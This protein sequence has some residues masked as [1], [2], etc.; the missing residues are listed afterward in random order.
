MFRR[1]LILASVSA[2]A[3]TGCVGAQAEADQPLVFATTTIVGDLVDEV[4]H[5]T[6]QLEILMPIGADPHDFRPSARQTDALRD[7]DLIVT[8]G[9]GLETGLVDALAVARADGVPILELGAK[10]G[11]LTVGGDDEAGLDP[12]WWLDPNRA[13]VAVRLIAEQLSVNSDD[14][15]VCLRLAPRA[16]AASANLSILGQQMANTLGRVPPDHR[17]LYM[18]Q[19]ELRYLAERFGFEVGGII[20]DDATAHSRSGSYRLAE[21]AD[22]M[23]ADGIDAVFTDSSESADLAE[24]LAAEAGKGTEVVAL[25]LCSLGGPG[26]DAE[27]YYEMML[28]TAYRIA[29]A[30]T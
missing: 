7:A 29:E 30:L 14:P 6:V 12:H 8:S 13:A 10:L 17:R 3:L 15:A 1:L 16:E 20:M 27:T 24:S 18:A 28:T 19:D 21:L 25:D 23:R 22:A 2:L 11:P 26:S 4:G 9:L 5:G